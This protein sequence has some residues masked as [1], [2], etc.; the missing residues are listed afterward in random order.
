MAVFIFVLTFLACDFFV[1]DNCGFFRWVEDSQ[2][3]EDDIE[4]EKKRRKFDDEEEESSDDS[5]S[6]NRKVV[7]QEKG[8]VA[9]GDE[10]KDKKEIEGQEDDEDEMV[11]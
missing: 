3:T 9:K 11:F 7:D 1:Q 6:D 2:P 8:A 5:D 4:R 10:A